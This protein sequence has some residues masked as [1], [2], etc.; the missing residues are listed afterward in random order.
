MDTKE[1]TLSGEIQ[2]EIANLV[3][4]AW[5]ERKEEEEKLR[6]EKEEAERLRVERKTDYSVAKTLSHPCDEL[7]YKSSKKSDMIE[8]QQ[9]SDEILILSTL[10]KRDPRETKLWK[11]FKGGHSELEKAMA[12]SVSGAGAEWIPTA[13]SADLIDRVRMASIVA[14]I[15]D[16]ITMPSNPYTLPIV[17]SDSVAYRVPEATDVP[18]NV[19]KIKASRPGT[20]KVTFSATTLGVRV[21]FSEELNEDIIIPILPFLRQNIILALAA[22][23]ETTVI[24]GDISATHM[25]NDVTDALDARKSWNGYRKTAIPGAKIDLGG[26]LSL[27]KLR[28]IKKALRKYGIYP[29]ELCWIVGTSGLDQILGLNSSTAPRDLVLTPDKYGPNITNLIEGEQC[30]VDN[31]P[32]MVSEHVREDLN[33]SGVRD[34][35]TVNKTIIILVHRRSFMFGDR[36][37]VTIKTAENI[38]TDQTLLVVTQR[39][40]FQA[41]QPTTDPLVGIGYN[42]NS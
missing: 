35:V 33:A 7:I 25:D 27:E 20:R 38:E 6:I 19:P 41:L 10:L 16:R 1:E 28:S 29:S 39:L 23:Q 14:K 31:I 22:G 12:R 21:I 24:N 2:K 15:H 9:K 11:D 26:T 3:D 5:T 36:R 34:G 13:F 4:K 17:G 32:V 37:L 42:L 18:E 40:D 30:R 8:L